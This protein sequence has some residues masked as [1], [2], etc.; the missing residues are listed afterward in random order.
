VCSPLIC[1]T[2][3]LIWRLIRLRAPVMIDGG[4]KFTDSTRQTRKERDGKKP[5]YTMKK[6][7]VT[8]WVAYGKLICRCGGLKHGVGMPS[9][10]HAAPTSEQYYCFES[11]TTRWYRSPY[12]LPQN[13]LRSSS[14]APPTYTGLRSFS[15]HLRVYL[16]FANRL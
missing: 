11:S 1:T 9:V 5:R 13:M 8:P 6:E 12:H 4:I 15:A 3:A 14:C 2:S 10:S 16:L 7:R